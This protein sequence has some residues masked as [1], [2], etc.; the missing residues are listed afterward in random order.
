[1]TDGTDME[2]SDCGLIDVLSW[3]LSGE[4]DKNHE[5]LQLRERVYQLGFKPRTF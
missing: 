5:K 3:H 2:R 1:M 4:T